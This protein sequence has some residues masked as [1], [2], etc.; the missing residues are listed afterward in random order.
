MECLDNE[1]DSYW[2]LNR[3]TIR[4]KATIMANVAE[5]F[6]ATNDLESSEIWVKYALEQSKT[7]LDLEGGKEIHA[8]ALTT[9][10][11]ICGKKQNFS[12]CRELCLEA[13]VLA[14][15]NGFHGI[16]KMATQCIKN[17]S[18]N[19]NQNHVSR[20]IEHKL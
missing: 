6:F 5:I 13:M 18:T 11:N 8:V 20:N 4:D 3:D 19:C 1:K 10:G 12:K 7:I 16:K 15:E 9:F 14:R 17:C 2:F